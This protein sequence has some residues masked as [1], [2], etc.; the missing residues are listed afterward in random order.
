M[1]CLLGRQGDDGP[2]IVIRNLL[3]ATSDQGHY[4]QT[5]HI[6]LRNETGL[7]NFTSWAYDDKGIVIRSGLFISKVGVCYYHHFLNNLNKNEAFPV[8]E[9]I[10]E[11]YAEMVADSVVKLFECKILISEEMRNDLNSGKTI[12]FEWE[13]RMKQ[14]VSNS[15]NFVINFDS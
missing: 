3:Y 1:I 5:M 2:K 7:I 14:F 10:L 12:F 15:S 13:H 9:C 11:L 4:L 6:V 8:G